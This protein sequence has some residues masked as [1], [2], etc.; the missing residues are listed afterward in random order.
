MS[1]RTFGIFVFILFDWLYLY[2]GTIS[3][4]HMTKN[5]SPQSFLANQVHAVVYGKGV[6]C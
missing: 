2:P 3:N 4:V 1:F 5:L 6:M